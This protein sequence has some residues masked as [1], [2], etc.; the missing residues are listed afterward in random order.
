VYDPRGFE[1]E[2]TIQNLLF[3]LQECDSFK[4]KGLDGEFVYS[5]S[6]EDLVLLPVSS[7]EYRS[8]VDYTSAHD[9]KVT[10]KEMILGCLYLNRKMDEVIYLGRYDFRNSFSWYYPHQEG[11]VKKKHV[12]LHTAEKKGYWTQTGFTNLASRLTDEP[13]SDF[14]DRLQEFLENREKIFLGILSLG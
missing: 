8:C 3:I 10:K 12:F 7:S 1:F 11:K 2:I 4:G 9:K 6:G 5:W 13:V 14:S